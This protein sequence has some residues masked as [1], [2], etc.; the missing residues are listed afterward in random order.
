MNSLRFKQAS[1]SLKILTAYLVN[2]IIFYCYVF[3]YSMMFV[4]VLVKYLREVTPY[5]RKSSLLG[6]IGWGGHVETSAETMYS[7][8]GTGGE[9]KVLPL[10]LC[11]V[12]RNVSMP[13]ARHATIEIHAPNARSI[14]CLR[15]VDDRTAAR[16]YVAIASVTEVA[17]RTAITEANRL[18][19]DDSFATAGSTREV[20][21]IG[22]LAEEV[23]FASDINF[24][25]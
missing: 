16:W 10:H 25:L 18:L 20:K 14:I 7:A 21:H 11:F 6:D 22:W 1:V 5:F 12:C 17:S 2:I 3:M 19:A 15:A 23:C 4:L 9:T 13:D 24:F 8:A